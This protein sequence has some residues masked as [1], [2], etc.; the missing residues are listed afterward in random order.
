[1]ID[2]NNARKLINNNIVHK[3]SYNNS[4]NIKS[5]FVNVLP[6]LFV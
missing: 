4:S 1:M 6:K 3:K 2:Q 5:M